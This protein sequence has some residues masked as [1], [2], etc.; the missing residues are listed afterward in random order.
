MPFRSNCEDLSFTVEGSE[1]TGEEDIEPTIERTDIL[2]NGVPAGTTLTVASDVVQSLACYDEQGH[3]ILVA[4]PESL[5]ARFGMMALPNFMQLA[6]RYQ[7]IKKFRLVAETSLMIDVKISPTI[8]TQVELSDAVLD[9]STGFMTRD[10]LP[11]AIRSAIDRAE[12][13]VRDSG[14]RY[15]GPLDGGPGEGPPNPGS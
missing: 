10:Q 13:A 3:L 8:S 7:A 12:K 6:K 5:G 1:A 4:Q 14:G 11:P 2:T 15:D 9:P